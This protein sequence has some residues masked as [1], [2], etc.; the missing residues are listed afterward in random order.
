VAQLD[1]RDPGAAVNLG[2]IAQ[3][4]RDY[5]DAVAQFTR[6][7][8]MEPYNVTA[9]YGLAT[10]LTRAGRAE[11]A[12]TAMARFDELRKRD[13]GTVLSQSYLEQ[14]RYAEAL[15]STGAERAL[16]DRSTPL[17][18]YADAT[19]AT[20]A[21]LA[22]GS[23]ASE[24]LD[25]LDRDGDLDLA[26]L[27]DSGLRVLKNTGG[28]FTLHSEIA[29]A[30][31][32]PRHVVAGD[33]DNDGATDLLVAGEPMHRF[34]MQQ[35]D[36]TFADR[37]SEMTL[38]PAAG[39]ADALAVADLDH[40]GDLDLI[41]GNRLQFLRNNGNLT[42]TDLTAAAGF[43]SA[44]SAVRALVA[45]DFDDRRDTD[46]L[47]V[48]TGAAP[49][50]YRNLRDG[51]F[52][53]VARDIGLPAVDAYTAVALGDFNKDLLPDVFL[54]REQSR[55]LFLV[56]RS[57]DR[58]DVIDA[59]E[60]TTGASAAML[61]DYDRDGLLDLF[62]LTPRGPRAWRHVGDD[63]LDVSERAF[64]PALHLAGDPMIAFSAGDLDGDADTDLLVRH[65]SGRLRVLRNDDRQQNRSVRVRLAPRVS[66]RSAVGAKVDLRA[67]ALRQRLEVTRSAPPV[68]PSD[69]VFG[70]G[71]RATADVARV[72][73]PAGIL[74]AELTP[75]DPQTISELDRKP[76]SC[77]YLYTWNGTRFE[78]VTDFLGGGEMGLWV[79]PSRQTGSEASPAF[80]PPSWS[81]PDADEYVR[82]REDQLR[83]LNGRYEI[84]VTNELEEVTFVDRL[85]LVAIDHAR[86][87]IVFPNEGLTAVPKPYRLFTVTDANPPVR[88]TDHH[89]HD[90]TGAVALVDRRYP[91]DF[92]VEPIRGYAETHALTLDLGADRNPDVLL[93]TGWT[94][95]AFSS[96][97]VAAHQAGLSM[98]PPSLQVKDAAGAWQT[99][100]DDIGFPVGRPQTVTVD[101]AGRFLSRSRE[102][103]IVTN[104]RVYWDQVLAGRHRSTPV[105][106]TRVAP[107]GADLAW[108]G[109]S[110]AVTPEGRE[111]FVYDYAR[112]TATAP[113]KTP[114]GAYTREGDVGPLLL[115]AD[116][117]FVVSMPGDQLAVSWDAAAFPPLAPD[118]TRTFL[119]YA[120][121]YSKEMNARSAS[122]DRVEPL[123]FHGMTKYPYD[124]GDA[125]P[126]TPTHQ[127]YLGRYQT[128][129]VKKSVPPLERH[130]QPEVRRP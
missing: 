21:N 64:P 116:D 58:V 81:Y 56:S 106:V 53:D 78:F 36:G 96:D 102:V 13:Y 119:L 41:V 89:G 98:R 33:F 66:N 55:G 112:V 8:E 25:D 110:A 6:A 39:R 109:F 85:E 70:L 92:T 130:I 30:G 128:R 43:S 54:G 77:P 22:G 69:L 2:Q 15:V 126:S 11:D 95:Y 129:V 37:T 91:D 124:A 115:A 47:A 19:A 18:T 94:D 51:R 107:A 14:G 17:V 3:E 104:M 75:A 76:S 16:V 28:T 118:R 23:C 68:A 121:G 73:W 83:P 86:D 5:A 74:Q 52:R 122:P 1:P 101:L 34:V 60:E 57:A 40:D 114:A 44:P 84:R 9:A 113:W 62:V 108:R 49:A 87:A 105:R 31:T 93:L 45:T 59:P 10:A 99:V 63:W 38:P 123:P 35:R 72:L 125:A 46:V 20:L 120:V 50:L 67:G 117:L 80:Q 88:A 65:A 71:R 79:P 111:P 12:A 97:N 90:V 127:A 103:R 27:C 42:F 4:R 29:V 24:A 61:V 26:L 100:I 48:S 7:L 32:R 82:I